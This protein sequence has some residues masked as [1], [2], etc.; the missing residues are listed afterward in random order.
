MKMQISCW[1]KNILFWFC[2]SIEC[3]R[4]VHTKAWIWRKV[5]RAVSCCLQ[6]TKFMT[7]SKWTLSKWE[8]W[9]VGYHHQKIHLFVLKTLA[10]L[11]YLWCGYSTCAKHYI[12]WGIFKYCNN[13]HLNSREEK[14]MALIDENQKWTLMFCLNRLKI[15]LLNPKLA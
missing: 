1:R 15:I 11:K 2:G 7:P 5:H 13:C 8:Y 14:K 9:F 3:C 12:T 6:R 10:Y 4:S